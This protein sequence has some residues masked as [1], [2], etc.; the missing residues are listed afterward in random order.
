M[1]VLCTWRIAH[2]LVY[3]PPIVNY[4]RTSRFLHWWYG[5]NMII[6]MSA[7]LIKFV[8]ILFFLK[9]DTVE[10]SLNQTAVIWRCWITCVRP[11]SFILL[12][13]LDLVWFS[14]SNI[15]YFN[16]LPHPHAICACFVVAVKKTK[17]TYRLHIN[18]I[19]LLLRCWCRCWCRNLLLL[20]CYC[21]L[22]FD[23]LNISLD[24]FVLPPCRGK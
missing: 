9:G 21:C 19:L 10:P 17:R 13:F 23:Y 15:C 1:C 5:I 14:W 6:L 20:Y 8:V 12:P 11:H 24:P 3:S 16:W 2:F 18:Y 22:C 7:F 4:H